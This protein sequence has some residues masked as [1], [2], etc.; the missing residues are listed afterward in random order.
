[1][2]RK[3]GLRNSYAQVD[4]LRLEMGHR[5]REERRGDGDQRQDDDEHARGHA[6]P[7]RAEAF[8][9]FI[10]V[11]LRRARRGAFDCCTGQLQL[12]NAALPDHASRIL[13]SRMPYSTSAIRLPA[14]TSSV[15]KNVTPITVV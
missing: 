5:E 8:P 6:D 14:T 11:A 2:A 3:S 1:M 15:A 9:G 4:G 12:G 10:P 7:V 13:G